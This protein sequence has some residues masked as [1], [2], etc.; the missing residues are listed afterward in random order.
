MELRYTIR[1]SEYNNYFNS[2]RRAKALS[3]TSL[4]ITALMTIFPLLMPTYAAYAKIMSGKMLLL[5]A[6]LAIGLSVANFY[7]RS[8][9]WRNTSP[10]K[11]HSQEDSKRWTEPHILT[12][13]KD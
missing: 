11:K 12:V 4:A 6:V 2:R 5:T 13:N 9:S 1:E 7:F 3:P 10:Q 8:R